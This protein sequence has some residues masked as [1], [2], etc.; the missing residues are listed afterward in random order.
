MFRTPIFCATDPALIRR[1]MVSDFDHFV[2]HRTADLKLPDDDLFA[3]ILP[4][5][6]GDRWRH[7][8]ATLSPSFTGSKMRSM[9]TLVDA[10]AAE[11]TA[12]LAWQASLADRQLRDTDMKDLFSKFALDVIAT[13]A[14]GIGV[15]SFADGENEFLRNARTMMNGRGWQASL[16]VLCIQYAP[17]LAR[18]LGLQMMDAGVVRFFER[19]VLKTMDTRQRER[20]QRPDVIEL[21]M[22]CRRKSAI[23]DSDKTLSDTQI[24]A[25]CFMF[26]AAG[27]ETT[28]SV[29]STLSYELAVNAE[30]QERLYAECAE[31]R[32]RIAAADELH[33]EQQ[34]LTYDALQHQMPYMEQVVQEVLRMWPPAMFSERMCVRPW[35]Y[36]DGGV[37]FTL[38]V[39]SSVWLPIYS[40]QQDEK[41]WAEARRFDPDRFAAERKAEIVP[42]THLP[43]GL[44]PRSCIAS[45]FA[46]MEM[47]A[48]IYHMMLRFKFEPCA[49]TQ[50]PLLLAKVPTGNR[51]DKGIHLTMTLRD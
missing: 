24:V 42:G 9:F 48:A 18:A 2:D 22:Q 20:I 21:L 14:F 23:D 36:D 25:Q 13:T 6:N 32:D 19:M 38:P 46:L 30:V 31:L 33:N 27:F 16:R 35:T 29:L 4:I 49:K 47:K 41:Y 1:I 12:T 40:V 28:S 8:R 51:T 5:L 26:F 17:R 34:K 3:Q 39:G 10:Y 37:R 15:N 50:I 11:M 7:M 43:F 44:G 45:R